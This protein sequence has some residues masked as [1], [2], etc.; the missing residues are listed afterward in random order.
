[1][2]FLASWKR[3]LGI[4]LISYRSHT[5]SY[6]F[7]SFF[8]GFAFL[9]GLYVEYSLQ[10]SLS[11]FYFPLLSVRNGEHAHYVGLVV[12]YIWNREKQMFVALGKKV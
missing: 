7:V 8:R 11:F 2:H 6:S 1:M 3:A 5:I 4:D 9:T 12:A 10:K